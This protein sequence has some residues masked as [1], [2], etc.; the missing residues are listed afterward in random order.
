MRNAEN[1]NVLGES[2]NFDE[3]D[4]VGDEA[5][6]VGDVAGGDGLAG[7]ECGGGDHAIGMGTTFAT[8]FVKQTGG[9]FGLIFGEWENATA[10]DGMHGIFL[11][12]TVWAVAEL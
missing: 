7:A 11:F 4:A 12:L 1:G 3:L 5:L 6:E 9:E 2:G 10:E 8:G